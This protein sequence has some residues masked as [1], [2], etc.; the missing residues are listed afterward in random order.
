M[1]S[2]DIKTV[3]SLN[4]FGYEI[5]ISETVIVTWIV[6]GIL[7]AASLILTRRLKEIPKGPQVILESGVEFLYKFSDKHFGS[8]SNFLAPYI[9]SIFIFLLIANMIGVISPFEAKLFGR[10]FIPPFSMRPPTSDINVTAALAV[11]SI[12]LILVCGFMARGLRGWFKNLFHPV[13]FMLPFNIMEYGIRLLSLTL[14]L[15]GNI[16][17]AYV[18]M[19]LIEEIFPI[20]LPMV[21]S[22]YFDFFDGTIQAIIFVFLTSLYISEAVSIHKE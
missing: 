11:I 1:K 10:T 2:L 21:F 4:L 13:P 16:L 7:I 9:G 8:F 20:A 14:R 17:A 5:P 12:V 3:F 22:L 18:L 6:M 15:F 19:H